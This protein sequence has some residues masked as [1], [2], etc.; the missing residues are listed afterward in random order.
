MK[1]KPRFPGLF[2][3]KEKLG[4]PDSSWLIE[5]SKR[6]IRENT[7]L[8]LK[9]GVVLSDLTEVSENSG[10]LTL[11]DLPIL[12][13]ILDTQ[14]TKKDLKYHPEMSKRFHVTECAT[15]RQ[16]RTSGRFERYC[17]TRRDDGLFRVYSI[18][19]EELESRLKLCLNCFRKI[20]WAEEKRLPLG[21]SN[22]VKWDSFDIAEYFRKYPAKFRRPPSRSSDKVKPNKYSD[23]WHEISRK[24]RDRKKWTCERCH[25]D[26]SSSSR[27]LDV[28]HKD[29]NKRNN[30]P[31]NLMALCKICHSEQPHHNHMGVSKQDREEI[32]RLRGNSQ[33]PAM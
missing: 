7:E 2:N 33:S 27:L 28:H 32:I 5:D 19:H 9:G 24:Y 10:L 11:E 20:K 31:R 17:V 14:S 4:A 26:L 8:E 18:D 21:S 13:Y 12:V 15:I 25:V 6:W 29:G 1:L 16:M 30:K 22:E 23:D 3:L